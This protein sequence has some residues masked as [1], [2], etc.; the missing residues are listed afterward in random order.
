MYYSSVNLARYSTLNIPAIARWFLS[1]DALDKLEQAVDFAHDNDLEIMALGGGSNIVFSEHFNGLICHNAL[2][3]KQVIDE[4]KESVVIEVDSGENWH[5][6]VV[7]TLKNKWYGLE[8]L[9]LIPGTVGAAPMQ[10]IGAYDVELSDVFESLDTFVY[11][12]GNTKTM[13]GEQCK[14]GY[15]DSIF[16]N[17]MLDKSFITKVR[18]RLSKTPDNH[19]EYPTL[20]NYLLHHRLEPSPENIFKAICAIRQTRLPDPT[21]IPNAGSFYKNPIV[22]ATQYKKILKETPDLVAREITT[23]KAAGKM[24]IS[25][26]F[27]I[28]K[29]KWKGFRRNG[30]GIHHNQALVLTNSGKRSGT[31]ILE[32]S[33]QIVDSIKEKF[34][35]ELEVEPQ[36]YPKKPVKHLT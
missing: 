6:L 15:R 36:I 9:A 26:G 32:F 34:D 18:L 33:S 29:A 14:L 13:N 21:K 7:W 12:T 5:E 17:A 35:I 24:K 31:D 23:G 10:N 11:K 20:K 19:S 28:E 16:K 22:S 25:A 3:G 2:L 8:N 27:L 30:V 4:D 1:V